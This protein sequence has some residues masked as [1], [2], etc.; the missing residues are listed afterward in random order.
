MTDS[1]APIPT[2]EALAHLARFAERLSAEKEDVA[3]G[4]AQGRRLAEAVVARVSSPGADISA[5]DGYAV[6]LAD[7]RRAGA[8]LRVIGAAPAGRPFGGEV[9]AGEAVRIF[10]GSV[11]PDGADHVVIQEEVIAEGPSVRCRRDY[12]RSEYVRVK[13]RDFSEGDVL[14]PRGAPLLPAALSLAAAANHGHLPVRRRLTVGVLANGDE[15]RPPGTLLTKGE[16]AN[17][18]PVG[19]MALVREWGAASID[20]GAAAD[21]AADIEERIAMAPDVDIFVAIGGASV[22]DHDLMRPA[23]AAAGFS[24]LFSRVAV[25]P[26][27]PTWFATRGGQCVLGLPGN[28]ASAFVCAHI[29]LRALLSGEEPR[30][31]DMPLSAPLP[32]GGDREEYLRATVSADASGRLSARCAPDQDSALIRPFLSANALVPRAALDPPR[33]VGELVTVQMI[34]P[35]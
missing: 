33:G 27:K 3:I 35:L 28:P 21:A 29:F 19:L 2:A 6:R 4:E 30:R 26:G 31:I 9:R 1:R 5:M 24:Q 10:T 14:L 25:K 7:V 23:F 12:A 16:I 20:L 8:L 34:A 15:L 13:G 11:M 22:G 17:S 32:R 18:N